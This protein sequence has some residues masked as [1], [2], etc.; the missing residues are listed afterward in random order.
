M[1]TDLASKRL[2]INLQINLFPKKH[3]FAQ[4]FK[5]IVL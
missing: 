5:E 1:Q 3:N 2:K 4:I